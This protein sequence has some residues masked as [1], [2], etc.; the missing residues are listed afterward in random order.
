MFIYEILM[1]NTKN[2]SCN[3]ECNKMTDRILIGLLWIKID[4]VST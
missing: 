4:T 2:V 1:F 3:Q